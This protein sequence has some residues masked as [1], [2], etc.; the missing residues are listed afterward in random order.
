MSNKKG[1]SSRI[2]STRFVIT[3]IP[4]SKIRSLCREIAQNHLPNCRLARK[5]EYPLQLELERFLTDLME[6][7]QL[8]A[9]FAKRKTIMSKDFDLIAK[10]GIYDAS[11][12]W[13]S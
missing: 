4:N 11:L 6:K 7:A 12:K 9:T 1:K 2:R 5:A 13:N 10:L 3:C 8:I